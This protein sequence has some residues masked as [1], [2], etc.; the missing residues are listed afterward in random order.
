[1]LTDGAR[2]REAGMRRAAA[3]LSLA[4]AVM[5]VSGCDSETPQEQSSGDDQVEVFNWWASGTEK[6]GLDALVSVFTHQNPGTRFVDGAIP[7]GAGSAAKDLLASRLANQDPPDTFQVHAGAELADHVAAGHLEDLSPLYGELGLRDVLPATLVDL[8]SVEGAPYAVPSNVHRANVLWSNTDVLAEA[9]LD[10]SGQYATLDE[11]FAAL[12]A[13]AATGRS[14]LAIGS[15][16]TQVHLLEQVLLARLG[17]QGYAGLWDGTTDAASADVTGAL[18]DFARLLDYTDPDRDGLDWQ[19]A[20]QRVISGE[21]AFTVMGDWALVAFEV[22]GL[23]PGDGVAWAPAPGTAGT[24]DVLVDAFAVPVGA[25]HPQSAARWLTTVSSRE[26]QE[27]LSTAKGAI[28]ARS[29]IDQEDLGPYQEAAM[30]AFATDTLVPSLAHGTAVRTAT[31]D[32]I[33]AAVGR[34]SA[35]SRNV[36]E[37]QGALVDALR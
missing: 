24:F 31:L 37:L 17:A 11:W 35:G 22:G 34:F 1:M 18:E 4:L 26:A 28:P 3:F 13:V 19:E 9:G 23:T 5:A 8:L 33:T 20:T 2:R 10:P 27:A 7:G 12:D 29:D 15:T 30:A 14:P 6:S 25:P 21:A 32:Q 36:A 16:W